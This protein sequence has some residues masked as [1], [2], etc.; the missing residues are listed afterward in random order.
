[1]TAVKRGAEPGL[2]RGNKN[3]S[4]A[5]LRLSRLTAASLQLDSLPVL[6]I[7]NCRRYQDPSALSSPHRGL[8]NCAGGPS[9]RGHLLTERRVLLGA[10][11]T[12]P[13][14]RLESR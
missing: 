10:R 7:T 11:A 13:V 1:M 5:G 6:A 8:V 12:L 9:E 4:R 2:R 3:A 14:S